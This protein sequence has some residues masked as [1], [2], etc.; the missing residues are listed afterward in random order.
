MIQLLKVLTGL[1]LLFVFAMA[2]GRLAGTAHAAEVGKVTGPRGATVAIYDD[3]GN[4]PGGTTVAV[5]RDPVRDMTVPGCW[6]EWQG[7]IYIGFADLDMF[8]FKSEALKG[9]KI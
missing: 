1:L 2:G 9:Q 3:A 6:F 5:Y 7:H 4:C 8:I